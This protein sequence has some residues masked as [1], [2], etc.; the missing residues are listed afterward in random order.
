MAR[1]PLVEKKES[2]APEH[3]PLYDAIA[4]SRGRVQGPFSALLHSPTIA[5]RTA[6]LGAYLRFESKLDPKVVELTALATARE[7]SCKHEWAAH[8]AHA[9]KAGISLDTIRAIHRGTPQDLQP[10][11]A[12]LVSYAQELLRSH[13]VS[14]ELF[15]AMHRRLGVHGLVE[16]TATIGYYAMLACTLNAFDVAHVTPPEDLKM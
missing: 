10:Q 7:L 1:I 13:Q 11:D 16:L 5:E 2:L 6:H 14:E 3:H 9:Q 8:I 12:E 4:Q 15:Q